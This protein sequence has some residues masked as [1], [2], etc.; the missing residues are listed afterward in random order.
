MNPTQTYDS[1]CF[2]FLVYEFTGDDPNETNT[3]IRRKL[4]RSKLGKFDLER[5][6][7]IRSLKNELLNEITKFQ[8]SQFYVGP[9]GKYADFADFD[10]GRMHTAYAEKYP[11]LDQEIPGFIGFAIYAYYLR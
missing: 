10:T 11:T 9:H 8:K 6:Q 3:K 4:A 5:V 7:I 1:A 2:S